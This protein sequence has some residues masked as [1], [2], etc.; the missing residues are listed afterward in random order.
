MCA[1]GCRMDFPVGSGLVNQV[2]GLVGQETVADV[3]GARLDSI[4]NDSRLIGHVVIRFVFFL[5]PFHDADGFVDAGLLDVNL[6]EA[7]Y[8]SLAA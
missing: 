6:L 1:V 7:T 2:D 8:H 3:A 4:F 5:Q